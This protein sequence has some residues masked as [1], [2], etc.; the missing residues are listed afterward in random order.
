MSLAPPTPWAYAAF[1][2]KDFAQYMVYHS[3][4]TTMKR[5]M[6]PLPRHMN[7]QVYRKLVPDVK[8]AAFIAPN[9]HVLGNVMMGTDSAVMYHTCVRGMSVMNPTRIGDNS[10]IGDRVTLMGYPFIGMSSFIDTG[11]TLD[12]CQVGNNVYIGPGCAIQIGAVIEDG[13]ILAPGSVVEKDV[14]VKARELWAGNPAHCVGEVTPQQ[15]EEAEQ[16]IINAGELAK[17]HAEAIRL[18]YAELPE[19]LDYEWL[20]KKCQQLE[21]TQ[22][23]VVDQQR[24]DIPIEGQRFLQPRVAYRMPAY[25]LRSS[26]PTARMAPWIRKS[27]DWDGNA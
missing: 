11:C 9:A 24:R 15:A 20:M 23:E 21:Q 3:Y 16:M 6:Y 12:T 8:N 5:R 25:G 4:W 2:V 18:H 1:F 19:V 22:K 7:V 14:H 10:I 27:P 17:A 13:V 26:S